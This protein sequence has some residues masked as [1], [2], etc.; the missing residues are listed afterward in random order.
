MCIRLVNWIF[1]LDPVRCVAPDS[2]FI[3]S[4]LRSSVFGSRAMHMRRIGVDLIP[5]EKL[6]VK[7]FST[8]VGFIEA[9]LPIIH[10]L[11]R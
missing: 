1:D 3:F 7:E 9:H 8:V 2:Y 6:I 10:G 5:A 11:E 4:Y